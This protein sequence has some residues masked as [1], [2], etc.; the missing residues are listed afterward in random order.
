MYMGHKQAQLMDVADRAKVAKS[1][2]AAALSPGSG[3]KNA[4]V[5]K[6]TAARIRK[7]AM[8]LGYR[9]NRLASGLRGASTSSVAA[10]WQF[11]D[12]WSLDASV[13][14]QLL[15]CFQADG[16]ATYQAEHPAQPERLVAVLEDLLERRPD[17]L[18]IQWRPDQL[19]H[20]GVRE[21]L[22]EFKAVVAVVPWAVRDMQID[23]VIYDRFSAIREVVE[24]FARSGRKHP[25]I[26]LNMVDAS[27]QRKY[28][29]FCDHCRQ[30]GLTVDDRTL[31]DLSDPESEDTGR[32]E[33]YMAAMQRHFP[34]DVDVDAIFC[35]ND[36]GVMAVAKVLRDRGVRIGRD[37]ALVG[38]N[39]PP[40]LALW[41][42]PLASID[43]NHEQLRRVI[44]DM[45]TE[46]LAQPQAPSKIRS[47]HMR[48]VWRESAGGVLES[49]E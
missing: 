24:H 9:P 36:V 5:G 41:D 3:G 30:L 47:V 33:R 8:E 22:K 28:A 20:E 49:R 34:G 7:I 26:T 29:V 27:D 4:R 25:C 46:R 45:V 12:P 2:V 15:A 44:Y 32:A 42:P 18:V 39:D 10:V 38:L 37:V 35:V 31:L 6:A 13:A 21:V 40:G 1:T 48:L 17:A 43:R 19:E 14:N 16:R 11:V 23:Q